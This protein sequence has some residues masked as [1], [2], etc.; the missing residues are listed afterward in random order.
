MAE[1]P[2]VAIDDAVRNFILTV[3]L[4][5][6]GEVLTEEHVGEFPGL[7]LKNK[8][9]YISIEVVSGAADYLEQDPVVD[10]DVFADSRA[11]AKKLAAAL[12]LAFL[13]YPHSVQVADRTITIDRAVC[14]S[15]P[16]KLPW[17]DE[18]IRRQSATY[19][20]SVRR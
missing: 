12:Q 13:R 3:P 7:G 15:L 19:Q 6:D 2:H 14:I 20:F 5:D 10:I 17:E 4:G 8:L 11:Q 9:P 1:E 18:K 16:V